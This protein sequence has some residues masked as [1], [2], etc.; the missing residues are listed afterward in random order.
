MELYSESDYLSALVQ[1]APPR[2]LDDL[3]RRGEQRAA[4]VLSSTGI[5]HAADRTEVY[6]DAFVR[7]WQQVRKNG[8]DGCASLFTYLVGVCRNTARE[9]L[10]KRKN[11][12]FVDPTTTWFEQADEGYDDSTL[13]VTQAEMDRLKEEDERCHTIIQLTF[14]ENR[15]NEE[16]V[17][18]LDV[19]N[20][21]V[22]A[23]LK[24]RCMDLLRKR[25][26]KRMFHE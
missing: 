1:G 19:K 24:S 25:I 9:F 13:R 4:N 17:S 18:V 10:R 12:S 14:F 11:T 26:A 2:I 5:I 16:L 6:H 15:R 8:H 3:Y 21:K 20:P 23:V 22:V 7:F